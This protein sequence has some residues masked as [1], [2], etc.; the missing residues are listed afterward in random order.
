MTQIFK[1][2]GQVA[3]VTKMEVGPCTVVQVKSKEKDGYSAV[4]F[5]YGEKRE[6]NIAK[7]QQGHLAKSKTNSRYLRE[8]RLNSDEEANVKVGDVIDIS[9][10]EAGD[11]IHITATSKGKGFQGVVKRHG[12][13]GSLKT[14]GHKDQHR[15]PGS[16][17]ATGPAHVFKGMRMGGHMGDDRVTVKNLEIIKIDSENSAIYVKGAVPGARNGL[18]MIIGDGELQ[19]RSKKEEVKSE[20]NKDESP[21]HSTGQAGIMNQELGN[22][23]EEGKQENKAEEVVVEKVE[24]TKESAQAFPSDEHGASGEVDKEVKEEK[25]EIKEEKVEDKKE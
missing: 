16:I 10:F 15:M 2:D 17:G 20:D 13:H 25:V 9:N 19:V 4:Q 11:K 12:F 7:P 18:V 21:S 1:E 14:H 22:E 5:G 3:P 8:L 23:K 24:E 6:K